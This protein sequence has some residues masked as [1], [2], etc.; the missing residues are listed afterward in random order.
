MVIIIVSCCTISRRNF[1]KVT[2]VVK[3]KIITVVNKAPYLNYKGR[4]HE[5]K[6]TG[7]LIY[8]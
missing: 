1:I 8:V 6:L 4:A 3:V 5:Y 7:G 2:A